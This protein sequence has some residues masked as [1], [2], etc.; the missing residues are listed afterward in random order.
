MQGRGEGYGGQAVYVGRE[1]G[2]LRRVSFWPTWFD[3]TRS[4]TRLEA[5]SRS[6]TR[7]CLS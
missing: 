2:G 1:D 4:I 6:Q 3:Y 7:S 5:R